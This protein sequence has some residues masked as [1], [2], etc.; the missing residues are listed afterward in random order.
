MMGKLFLLTL[1]LMFLISTA[2]AD[3]IIE[4]EDFENGV[5][6]YW[7]RAMNSFS[8]SGNPSSIYS[9]SPTHSYRFEL[10]NTDPSFE[11]GIRSELEGRNETPLQ[12]RWYNFSTYLPKGGNEDYAVDS[13]DCGE[14]IAQWHNNPDPGEEWTYPPLQLD[15]TTKRSENGALH[16]YYYIVSTWDD[17]KFSTDTQLQRDNKISE[18]NLGSYEDDKG[19]WVKW[20]FHVKWGWLESQNPKLE[21]YK[22]GVLVLNLN[23]KPN[24]MNDIKGVNQQFGLYKWEWNGQYSGQNSKLS[25]RVIYFDDMTVTQVDNSTT[26]IQ[27]PSFP[28]SNF[29]SNVTSGNAPLIVQF[30]DLSKNATRWYWDFGDGSTS[31]DQNPMKVY[32]IVG[33]YTVSLKAINDSVS[34]VSTKTNYISVSSQKTTIQPPIA[35]FIPNPQSGKSP[36]K[37]TFLD[38]STGKIEK[39]QWDFGDGSNATTQTATHTYWRK[40]AYT[41]KLTVSNYEGSSTAIQNIIVRRR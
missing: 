27:P 23:G 9:V 22:D 26:T 35:G 18:Y 20:S 2:T 10:Q 6:S 5:S 4:K 41:A 3:T 30:Y 12:E 16:G 36:L 33:N 14:V 19:K 17:N 34:N 1:I 32:S 11:D 15:T 40:G 21:V 31:S 24:T 7:Y 29:E 13:L 37:V 8:Y 39:W 25:K 28:V 38:Q